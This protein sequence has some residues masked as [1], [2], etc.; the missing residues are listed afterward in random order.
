[1][2]KL[3]LILLTAFSC[4]AYAQ[5]SIT[6]VVSFPAGGDTDVLA[7]MFA[8]QLTNRLNIPVIVENRTGASGTIGNQY[9]AQANPDGTTLLLTPNTM[10]MAPL[11]LRGGARYD[12]ADFTPIMLV[13][14]Q[15]MFV[16]VN[17]NTGV[18]NFKDFIAASKSNKLTGYASPGAGSP[19]HILGEVVNKS[20]GI[21]LTHIPYRGNAPAVIDLLNGQVPVMYTSL[22]PVLQHLEQGKLKVLAVAD[23]KRSPYQPNV[24]TLA[25]LGYPGIEIYGWM[26]FVGPKGMPDDLVKKLNIELNEILKMP[27]ISNRLKLLAFTSIGGSPEVLKQH[28]VNDHIRYSKIIKDVGI[29]ID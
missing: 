25:E 26:G 5:K 12:P 7:R 10:V 28:I 2:K 16:V 1:M 14:R 15:S 4:F 29:Q 11:L 9:V 18:I 24:P 6:V 19:M 17:S 27:E 13:S 22:V 21:N 20:T 23:N 8:E 3:L